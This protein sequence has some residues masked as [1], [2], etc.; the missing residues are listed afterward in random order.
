MTSQTHE[1]VDVALDAGGHARVLD[2]EG[3]LVARLGQPRQVHLAYARG[4]ERTLLEAREVPHVVGAE[5][6]LQHLLWLWNVGL[7]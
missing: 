1:V 3:A 2:L 6:G 5:L 7:F 4:R